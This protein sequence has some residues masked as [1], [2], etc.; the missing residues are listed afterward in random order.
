MK[1]DPDFHPLAARWLDGQATASE[2]TVLQEILSENPA[3][4]T[5]FAALCQTEV[6]LLSQASA[7]QA[8]RREALNALLSGKPWPERAVRMWRRHRN[9]RWSA[10]AALLVVG[11]GLWMAGPGEADPGSPTSANHTRP[12]QLLGTPGGIRTQPVED[13]VDWSDALI[14]PEL[15]RL[16]ERMP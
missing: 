10:A 13:S 11:A 15:R 16:L 5:E 12:P 9:I 14:D 7:D 2:Q 1:T 3:A 4:M 6:L 8:A